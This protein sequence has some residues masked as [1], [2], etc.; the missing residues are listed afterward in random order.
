MLPLNSFISD[1]LTNLNS[2]L[3]HTSVAYPKPTKPLTQDE[4][5]AKK[6][7]VPESRRERCCCCCCS[8]SHVLQL[9][10][11]MM[12]II[13]HFYQFCFNK[14]ESEIAR[15]SEFKVCRVARASIYVI[16]FSR[17]M[18]VH[19]MI[20]FKTAKRDFRINLFPHIYVDDL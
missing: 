12:L 14:L 3:H 7:Q 5:D 4:I 20:F 2:I 10:A 18:W 6:H 13:R 11:C 1:N 19:C 8:D 15:M 9:R 16:W 17:Q